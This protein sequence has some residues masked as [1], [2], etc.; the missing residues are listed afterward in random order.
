M[1]LHVH[2]KTM[3]TLGTQARKCKW[4]HHSTISPQPFPALQS[5]KQGSII[6]RK[7]RQYVQ[8]GSLV[9]ILLWHCAKLRPAAQRSTK[10]NNACALALSYKMLHLITL[11]KTEWFIKYSYTLQ[12]TTCLILLLRLPPRRISTT[13]RYDVSKLCT[14]DKAQY[15]HFKVPL[16]PAISKEP[17]KACTNGSGTVRLNGKV[18]VS[19]ILEKF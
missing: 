5:Q 1:Q 16:H 14:V 8:T 4:A 15:P 9:C 12:G 19:P 18:Q 3:Y 6:C 17:F 13:S 2:M 11:L 10:Y 7:R